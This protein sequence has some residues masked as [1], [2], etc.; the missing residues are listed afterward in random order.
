MPRQGGQGKGKP[1]IAERGLGKALIRNRVN[2]A[3]DRFNIHRREMISHLDNSGGLQEYLETVDLEDEDVEVLRVHQ[4]DAVL[5][6]P[7]V[8][9]ATLQTITSAQF[10]I[11]QLHIPRKPAWSVKMTAEEVD[12]NEKDAFLQW[13][14]D[15]ATQEAAE[16]GLQPFQIVL[17]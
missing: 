12:R 4:N 2:T 14:R 6:L 5:V 1:K 3:A 8:R 17:E 10:E 15:L 11:D 7:T 16:E 9:S 13:R